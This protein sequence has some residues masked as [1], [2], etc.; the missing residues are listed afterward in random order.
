MPQ[1]YPIASVSQLK[2]NSMEPVTALYLAAAIGLIV[3]AA[4]GLYEWRKSQ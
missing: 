4:V 3:G 2:G 1:R